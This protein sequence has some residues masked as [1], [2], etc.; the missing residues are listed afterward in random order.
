MWAHVTCFLRRGPS[1]QSFY[2]FHFCLLRRL[3]KRNHT[4]NVKTTILKKKIKALTILFALRLSYGNEFCKSLELITGHS[5]I[6][7]TFQREVQLE[8]CIQML[9]QRLIAYKSHPT[10]AAVVLDAFVNLILGSNVKSKHNKLLKVEERRRWSDYLLLERLD[11]IERW[12]FI[13]HLAIARSLGMVGL[14]NKIANRD[15]L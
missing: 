3:N 10:N 14:R 7:T 5:A 4:K 6:T 11:I 15:V 1:H 2:A 9:F 12:V 13:S 8:M